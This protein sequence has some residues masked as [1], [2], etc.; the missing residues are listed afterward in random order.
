MISA[1][2]CAVS[3]ETLKANPYNLVKDDSVRI[4]VVSVNVYGD[5]VQSDVGSGAVI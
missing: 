4:K 1:R 3:L 5:S 2:S